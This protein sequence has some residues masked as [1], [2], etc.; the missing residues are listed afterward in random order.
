MFETTNQF[1]I[2]VKGLEKLIIQ[3]YRTH[4]FFLKG[5]NDFQDFQGFGWVMLSGTYIFEKVGRQR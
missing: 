3:K 5:G 2:F 1:T 4:L